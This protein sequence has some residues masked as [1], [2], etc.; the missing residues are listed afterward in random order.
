[1]REEE[2]GEAADEFLEGI[3]LDS[4]AGCRSLLSKSEVVAVCRQVLDGEVRHHVV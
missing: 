3:G 1:V 2:E 4:R